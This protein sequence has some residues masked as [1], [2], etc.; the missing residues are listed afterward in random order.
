MIQDECGSDNGIGDRCG[1]RLGVARGMLSVIS[2]LW[3]LD[4][5]ALAEVKQP[6][7]S[8]KSG[9]SNARPSPSAVALAIGPCLDRPPRSHDCVAPSFHP[10]AESSLPPFRIVN[11]IP[12]NCW[13][14][15]GDKLKNIPAGGFPTPL[16]N[17]EENE[18]GDA[19]GTQL[20][21]LNQLRP[22]FT[23]RSELGT[24]KK[25]HS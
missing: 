11:E 15:Q 3:C 9:V 22:G 10:A 4:S 14:H 5:T 2:P 25:G 20:V 8:K 12:A 16:G 1:S 24:N 23:F 17:E 18:T 19:A 13:R 6:R 21:S 7:G